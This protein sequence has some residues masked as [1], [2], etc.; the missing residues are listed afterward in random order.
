MKALQAASRRQA[1]S[2]RLKATSI[3]EAKDERR[4]CQ[5]INATR[6]E[7]SASEVTLGLFSLYPQCSFLIGVEDN[8]GRNKRVRIGE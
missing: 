2:V 6:S 1:T 8:P 5:L 7:K 3:E 4:F